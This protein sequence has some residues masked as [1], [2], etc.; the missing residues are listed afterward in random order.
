MKLAA[1][2]QNGGRLT[3]TGEAITFRSAMNGAVEETLTY[4]RRA[5]TAHSQREWVAP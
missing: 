5:L 4:P 3:C 1:P 2:E